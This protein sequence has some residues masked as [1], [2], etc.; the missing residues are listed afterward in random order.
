MEHFQFMTAIEQHHSQTP[1]WRTLYRAEWVR[2]HRHD[3]RSAF[4]KLTL[5]GLAAFWAS[6][7]Y[8][9]YILG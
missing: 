6:I 7:A 2:R 1:N 8:G 5:L 4:W 9:I 3:G